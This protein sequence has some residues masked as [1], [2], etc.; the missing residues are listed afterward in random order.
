MCKHIRFNA[1]QSYL[2]TKNRNM[3]SDD[4]VRWLI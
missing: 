2:Q 3:L 1:C 4:V